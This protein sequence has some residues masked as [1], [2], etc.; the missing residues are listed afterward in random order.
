MAAANESQGLKI[1]VAAFI[2]LSVILAVTS[3][4]LYSAYS[5]AEGRLELARG[6]ETKA[7]TAQSQIL[8][9]YEDFRTKIGTRAQDYE[10]A[11]EEIANHFKKIDQRLNDLMNQVNA[12]VQRTQQA[13]AQGPELEDTKNKIVQAI[14][15]YRSEPN[16]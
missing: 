14:T 13:G 4:F 9:Q 16:K 7:K 12:A 3:Y 8:N 2:T 6:D 10:P 1:A 5:S 11:K 15:S